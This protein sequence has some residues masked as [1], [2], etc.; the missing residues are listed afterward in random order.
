MDRQHQRSAR[1]VMSK[2]FTGGIFPRLTGNSTSIRACNY[3]TE[4]FF[5]NVTTECKPYIEALQTCPTSSVPIKLRLEAASNAARCLDIYWRHAW[6]GIDYEGTFS[7]DDLS[8]HY[9][10]PDIEKNSNCSHPD[11]FLI[12]NRTCSFDLS[13]FDNT[14]SNTYR[15]PGGA[16]DAYLKCQSTAAEQYVRCTLQKSTEEVASCVADNAVKVDWLY[17]IQSYAGASS[18]PDANQILIVLGVGLFVKLV[19]TVFRVLGYHRT[20]QAFKRKT[21]VFRKKRGMG[22]ARDVS[23][24]QNPSSGHIHPEAQQNIYELQPTPGQDSVQKPPVYGQYMVYQNEYQP[25]PP[26]ALYTS[27]IGTPKSQ[28]NG[29]HSQNLESPTNPWPRPW[30]V[31]KVYTLKATRLLQSVGREVLV[32]YLTVLILGQ[33]G[34]TTSSSF[35][36]ELSFYLVRPRNAPFLGLLGIFEPWSQ[37]GVAELTVDG[38]LSFF[39]GSY[40]ASRYWALSRGAPANPAAPYSPQLY[41]LA[42]G[43]VMTFV[44]DFV[45]FIVTFLVSLGI[46][47]RNMGDDYSNNRNNRR[48]DDDDGACCG[49]CCGAAIIWSV[50]MAMLAAF[51][52]VLPVVGVVEIVA[53]IVMT[54]R[55]KRRVKKGRID[56]AWELWQRKRSTWEAPLTTDRRGFRVFYY[57]LVLGSFIINIGNWIF[58]ASYL[59]LEGEMYCPPRIGG[60]LAM[61]VFVPLGIDMV[62]FAYRVWTQDIGYSGSA[63]GLADGV[64]IP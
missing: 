8:G 61:W 15:G 20:R 36:E 59:K 55:H 39:A 40:V 14:C 29:Y 62:F 2:Q 41:T 50:W 30:T 5:T 23:A 46:A 6:Y 52:A 42:A 38:V 17:Q 45:L 32:A 63:P 64:V 25:P 43:S 34:F 21:R 44:P 1:L 60:V 9:R 53:T 10:P 49:L 12:L 51:I 3:T 35:A 58:F 26:P 13:A 4:S 54:I 48:K 24:A 37:Q 31:E 19:Q 7:S 56:G 11:F 16:N 47:A 57:F 28:G 22:Q 18:C 27:H 33:F